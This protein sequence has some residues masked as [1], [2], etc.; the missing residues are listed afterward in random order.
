MSSEGEEWKKTKLQEINSC[1]PCCLFIIYDTNHI[2]TLKGLSHEVSRQKEQVE[3]RK[4]KTIYFFFLTVNYPLQ[5]ILTKTRKISIHMSI[6]Y[7]F[8]GISRIYDL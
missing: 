1:L 6:N 2:H 5:Y 7:I 3:P 8:K 4:K